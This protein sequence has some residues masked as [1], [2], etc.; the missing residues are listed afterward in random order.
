MLKFW[1]DN[2]IAAI[3]SLTTADAATRSQ[4]M[5]DAERVYQYVKKNPGI[6][7][8]KLRKYGERNEMPP[9]RMTLALAVLHD[10]GQI[11]GV[12]SATAQVTPPTP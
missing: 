9:E 3:P 7:E 4:A 10:T 1:T 12:D 6:D 11:I 2:D 5:S 8:D